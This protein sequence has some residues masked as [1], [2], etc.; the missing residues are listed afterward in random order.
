MKA[1]WQMIRLLWLIGLVVGWFALPS[2]GA[3]SLD[4]F[5]SSLETNGV[6]VDRSGAQLGGIEGILHAIDPRVVVV[7]DHGSAEQKSPKKGWSSSMVQAVELWPENLAYLKVSGLEPGGGE[8]ILAHIQSLNSRWGVL[9]DL[10]GGQGEDL[11]SV[12]ILAGLVRSQH[13]PLFIITDNR[14]IALTTNTVVGAYTK[15]PLLMILVDEGTSGA[16][17]ALASVFKGSP[18]VMLIGAVTRGDPCLHAWIPLPG[19]RRAWLATRK[20]KPFQGESVEKGGVRPDIVV[21]ALSG[22]GN[23]GLAHTNKADRVLSPKSESD[24]E[25]MM[26]VAGDAVLQRATDVLLGIQAS[27]AYGSN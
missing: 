10:R 7:D 1:R 5:L 16:S 23:D 24:R 18:D 19:G 25:L 17:E 20:W 2:A 11:E 9:F 21:S 26:R 22:A 15:A 13:E 8:E 4:A 3:D 12:A 14:G 27:G 6:L